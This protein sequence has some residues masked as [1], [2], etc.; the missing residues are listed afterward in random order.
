[1]RP[2]ANLHF[3]TFT[4]GRHSFVVQESWMVPQRPNRFVQHGRPCDGL[5]SPMGRRLTPPF[6]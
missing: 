5:R 2:N 4:P 1:M 3:G 6:K